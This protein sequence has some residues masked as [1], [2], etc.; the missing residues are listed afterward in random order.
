MDRDYA[1]TVLRS[2]YRFSL[3]G[4]GL[5]FGLI[6]SYVINEFSKGSDL[7]SA[8]SSADPSFYATLD[9]LSVFVVLTSVSFIGLASLQGLNRKR[10][11]ISI[12]MVFATIFGVV[13]LL[14]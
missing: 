13:Y 9:V 10:S 7:L 8:F 2:A 1:E 14:Y 3:V 4:L 12:V 5:A 11:A 6:L